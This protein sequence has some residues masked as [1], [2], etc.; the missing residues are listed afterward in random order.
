MLTELDVHGVILGHSERR[1]LFNETDR[2]L[3]LKVLG[4]TGRRAGAV[5]VRRETDAE[6]E[7]GDT[8][9]KLRHQVR[10]ASRR[11]RASAS[12]KS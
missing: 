2:A 5:A 6:R 10:K 4:G 1:E 12:A 9:R 8:E 3:G 11:S 7:N